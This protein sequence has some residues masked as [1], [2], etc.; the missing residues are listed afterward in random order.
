ML[1]S[2][3]LRKTWKSCYIRS[4]RQ[5]MY[6]LEFALL[7]ITNLLKLLVNRF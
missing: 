4:Y 7:S 2:K 1:I 6:H 5:N 3:L